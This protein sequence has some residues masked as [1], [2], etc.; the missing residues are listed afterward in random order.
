MGLKKKT[1]VSSH[2]TN[3]SQVMS[4]TKVSYSPKIRKQGF[5]EPPRSKEDMIRKS[6][7]DY[8]QASNFYI[9]ADGK[10]QWK[11]WLPKSTREKVIAT[12]QGNSN[13][14]LRFN[15]GILMTFVPCMVL[16]ATASVIIVLLSFV[17]TCLLLPYLIKRWDNYLFQSELQI[18]NAYDMVGLGAMLGIFLG[19]TIVL[20]VSA[21]CS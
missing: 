3:A 8:L 13:L 2:D 9:D 4:E 5:S 14:V 6:L 10:K 19:M 16:L 7:R 12:Y 11:Q 17:G 21:L 1:S 15:L 18:K 20:F